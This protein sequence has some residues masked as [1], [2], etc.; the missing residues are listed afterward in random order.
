VAVQ[1]AGPRWWRRGRDAA[2]ARA[3]ASA[4][5]AAAAFV[6]LDDLQRRTA[7]QVDAV[8][9]LDRGPAGGHLRSGWTRVQH[10]ADL[11]AQ[12]Y[13]RVPEQWDV[14]ADLHEADAEL[15]DRAFVDIERMLRR[16]LGQVQAF[17]GQA[18]GDFARVEQ[19]MARLDASTRDADAAIAAAREAIS[20][21]EHDEGHPHEAIEALHRAEQARSVLADGAAVHGLAAAVA[22]ADTALTEA[23][24]ARE[25]AETLPA[26][27]A[28]LR[29][30][31]T[32]AR[33]RLDAVTTRRQRLTETLS[34]LRRGFVA[35]AY[36]DVETKPADADRDLAIARD[37]LASAERHSADRDLPRARDAITQTRRALDAASTAVDAVTGRLT[38]LEEL[39]RDPAAAVER[40]RFEI[41]EAQRLFVFL[42]DRADPWF[43]TRL[44]SL[45]NRLVLA[46]QALAA[47]HPDYWRLDQ[48]L[49]RIRAET[50]EV[51]QRLRASV[52]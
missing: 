52:A 40:T 41:R 39:R 20:R 10:E 32:A 25:R 15:A 44:D 51:V 11:A 18:A 9:A 26:Q 5:A 13:L 3:R 47:P 7:L 2:L 42:G 21:A 50:S 46:E 28:E 35:S 8:T 36:A 17:A 16:V 45:V 19:A 31:L 48:D 4:G 24:Q 27:R 43:A 23:R 29:R 30:A 49:A 37:R 6:A 12:A 14:E 38:V 1:G 34:A 33:T 22:A